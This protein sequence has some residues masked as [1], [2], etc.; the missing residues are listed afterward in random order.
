[1]A[2]R[3]KPIDTWYW[4]RGKQV[5]PNGTILWTPL[6]CSREGRQARALATKLRLDRVPP[7]V[8]YDV[9]DPPQTY[10]EE[11]TRVRATSEACMAFRRAQRTKSLAHGSSRHARHLV[12]RR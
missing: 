6:Y 9:Q 10:Q 12:R 4:V 11:M 2:E 5:A 7:Y 8:D 3:T 1:M